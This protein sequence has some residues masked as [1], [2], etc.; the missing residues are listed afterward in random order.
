MNGYPIATEAFDLEVYVL[1]ALFTSS[2]ALSDIE[3]EHQSLRWARATFERSE[4]SRRLLSL[5][6]MLRNQLEVS[7]L[8]PDVAVGILTPDMSTP[9]HCKDLSLRE[10]CNRIIHAESVDFAPDQEQQSSVRPSRV[11]SFWRVPTTTESGVRNSMP[12]PSSTRRVTT[13]RQSRR[14]LKPTAALLPQLT[15]DRTQG[16]D[17]SHL[18]PRA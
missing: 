4:V 10:A 5:A 2:R 18:L 1:A 13:S 7:V 11:Q 8:K 15:F 6:V 14:Q 16:L 3:H 17:P 9:S 12:W